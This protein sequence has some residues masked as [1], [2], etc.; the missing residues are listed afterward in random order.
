MRR[1]I[2]ALTISL[3]FSG[4]ADAQR[5]DQLQQGARVR[6][7]AFDGKDVKGTLT[8]M[9]DDSI[10]LDLGSANGVTTVPLSFVQTIEVRHRSH[11]QGFMIGALLGTAVGAIGGYALGSQDETCS[12]LSCGR[13]QNAEWA[14]AGYGF[15]GLALGSA[16]GLLVGLPT[17][18]PVSVHP[19]G[20]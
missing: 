15:V 8:M 9:T 4:V 12:L 18:D 14:A 3:V 10:S 19:P 1:M 2:L 16:T 6:V 20:R 7:T 5:T 13:E 11:W 17:W